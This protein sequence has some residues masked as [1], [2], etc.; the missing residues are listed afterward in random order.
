MTPHAVS[1]PQ[2]FAQI[3]FCLACLSPLLSFFQL[4]FVLQDIS[5]TTIFCP[6]QTLSPDLQGEIMPCFPLI[7]FLYTSRCTTITY[8]V[9]SASLFRLWDIFPRLRDL[10]DHQIDLS[11]LKDG[12]TKAEKWLAQRHWINL[13]LI[14]SLLSNLTH[15]NSNTFLVA[16]FLA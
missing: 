6:L 10:N 2:D 11:L 8:F 9:T 13:C 15:R 1:G 12:A 3:F 14:P 5:G 4:L 7:L 16:F